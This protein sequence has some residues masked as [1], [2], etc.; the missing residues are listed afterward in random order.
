MAEDNIGRGEVQTHSASSADTLH[1]DICIIGA[2][3]I[4]LAIA[5]SIAVQASEHSKRHRLHK[6]HKQAPLDILVLEKNTAAGLET[7]SRNSGVIH[8]GI[9]Y[10]E[11]S[12]KA[13]LCIKGN[14]LLYQYAQ[15]RHIPHRQIG[16][17]I[18][19]SSSARAQLE[20]LKKNA[21]RNGVDDLH[22]LDSA[23]IHQL[24]P[25][26]KAD[27]GLFSPSTGIIDQSAYIQA[28]QTETE[29]LG[30]AFA[31]LCQ[32]DAITPTNQSTKSPYLVCLL[33]QGKT[34]HVQ[35]RIVINAAGLG[36]QAIAQKT[37]G[38]DSQQVPELKACKGHYFSLSGQSPFQHLIYP[39]PEANT[40][41]LGIHA[42]LDTHGQV[43]FGPDTQYLAPRPHTTFEYQVCAS[44]KPA[45][46]AA[47]RQYYPGLNA[48]KLQPDFA[49]IRPKIQG[50]G[51]PTRDF[52]IR[53][54]ALQGLPGLINLFGIE[55]PGLTASLA[56]GDYVNNLIKAYV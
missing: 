32:V 38:L 52:I 18:V 56:I 21:E 45:F 15:K 5:R 40:T 42:T 47:I 17:L 49:G 27:I 13:Q 55:S 25:A 9:Y 12:L 54:E 16:K 33:N 28:L 39:L 23:Q 43:R 30:V 48:N 53:D 26:I 24:E 36:A 7:S 3:V 51:E 34:E 41:G 11:N 4:G 8:A 29:E 6:P 31:P 44:L 22:W 1:T 46:E 35:A 20:N 14:A 19:A 37:S 50:P 10:P 2:G